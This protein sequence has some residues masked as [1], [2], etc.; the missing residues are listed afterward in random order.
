MDVH[1]WNR[2]LLLKVWENIEVI[3]FSI[4]NK[5]EANFT[6]NCFSYEQVLVPAVIKR[7]QSYIEIEPKKIFDVVRI[8]KPG[9]K[10]FKTDTLKP[11]IMS[12]FVEQKQAIVYT[13]KT[14]RSKFQ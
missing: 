4:S 9:L 10:F 14:F 1:T 3:S 12:I 6:H 8:L 13:F 2:D 5:I 11:K 7:D